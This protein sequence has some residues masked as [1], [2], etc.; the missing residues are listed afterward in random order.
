MTEPITTV[1]QL[2]LDL[3]RQIGFNDFDGAK[4]ADGLIAHRDL[5]VGV[6][7]AHSYRPHP[8]L[9]LFEELPEDT[10]SPDTLWMMAVNEDAAKQLVDLCRGVWLADEAGLYS[11]GEMQMLIGVDP[12]DDEVLVRA[13][14]D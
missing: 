10:W 5:W 4:V 3:I 8:A 9:R 12:I 13:W 6:I 1:Q 2:H 11:Q 14:W 7:A